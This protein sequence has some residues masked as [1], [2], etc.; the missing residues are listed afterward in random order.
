M[1]CHSGNEC[2]EL[3]FVCAG[4]INIWSILDW[5]ITHSG[6]DC[7]ECSTK[8]WKWTI[9]R[10]VEKNITSCFKGI[11]YPVSPPRFHVCTTMFLKWRHFLQ[12]VLAFYEE[13]ANFLCYTLCPFYIN[14]TSITH[15]QL[16]LWQVML[17]SVNK[18]RV[19]I[20]AI[21][22]SFTSR[23]LRSRLSAENLVE[24]LGAE[25]WCE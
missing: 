23:K 18:P 5:Q 22:S 7:I 25:R 3:R 9:K 4:Q 21:C 24:I 11:V 6:S 14:A 2:L 12:Q 8:I 19:A 16:H 10:R 1:M 17:E 13:D 20:L 15:K